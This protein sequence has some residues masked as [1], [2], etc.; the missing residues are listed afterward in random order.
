MIAVPGFHE[1]GIAVPH[2]IIPGVFKIA[3]QSG[4]LFIHLFP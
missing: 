3:F 4:K 1:T 2:G